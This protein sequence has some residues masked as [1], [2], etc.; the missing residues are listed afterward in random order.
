MT[1]NCQLGE[2]MIRQ[3]E[4]YYDLVPDRDYD[5]YIR[6][7]FSQP[8]CQPTRTWDSGNSIAPYTISRFWLVLTFHVL[9]VADCFERTRT[10]VRI[11]PSLVRFAV[12]T[13]T[14]IDCELICLHIRHFTCRAFSFR[15]SNIIERFLLSNIKMRKRAQIPSENR[16]YDR[17]VPKKLSKMA[18]SRSEAKGLSRSLN[19]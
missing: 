6:N 4:F 3:L 14:L 15:Y 1:D 9:N 8:G 10:G 5:V 13:D 17:G 11:D 12:N 16:T 7:E 18:S 2:K 19:F